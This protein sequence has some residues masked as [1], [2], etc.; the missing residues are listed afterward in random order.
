MSTWR[1]KLR[2]AALFG[3]LWLSQFAWAGDDVIVDKVWMRESVPGQTAATVQLNLSVTPAARLLGVSSPLA[4]TGEIVS[5]ERRG[6]RM[7]AHALRDLRLAARSTTI[8]GVRGLYLMLRGLKQPLNV[9]DRVPVSL[10]LRVAGV[11]RTIEATAEVRALELSYK[12]YNDPAVM[13]HR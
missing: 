8:F 11:R 10:S 13:D 4:A 2:M 12:H 3:G 1:T 9:G 6:G 7:Q 5:V